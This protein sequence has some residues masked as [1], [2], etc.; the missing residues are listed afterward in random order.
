MNKKKKSAIIH[1]TKLFNGQKTAEEIHRQFGIRRRCEICGGPPV[2]R[3]KL[4]MLA[5]DAERLS[6]EWCAA[7]AATN[8]DGPFIPTI[9]TTYG[10]MVRFSDAVACMH[11][12]KELE[13][14]A[15]KAPSFVLVEIDRGPGA[16]N[17][18]VQVP[19]VN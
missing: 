16:D 12:R 7:I 18:I 4:M 10:P 8:P 17:P 13:S 14:A 9:P 3:V 15:A 5:K 1:R 19:G 6:P 11:H 2:I